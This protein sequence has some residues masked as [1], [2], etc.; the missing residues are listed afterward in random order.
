[1]K[2]RSLMCLILALSLLVCACAAPVEEGEERDSNYLYVYNYGTYIDPD[3]IDMFEEETGL[4]VVYDVFDT[5][6][7]MYPVI[8]SGSVKYDVVCASEY[9]VEKL[10]KNGYLSE[11]NLDNVPNFK[12]V[13]DICRQ[14]AEQ[15]DPGNKYSVPYNWGTVGILYN[16][17]MIEEGEITKWSDLWKEEYFDE[18]MMMDSLRDIY[19]APLCMLGYSINTTSEAEMREATDLLIKQKELVYSYKTDAIRDFLLNESAAIGQIYSGEAL[20][21]QE[22]DEDMVYV[23][24]EEGSNIWFDCWVIPKNAQ[25]QKNAELWI[26]F[27][28]RPEIGFMTYEYVGYSTPNSATEEMIKEEYPEEIDNQA[29]FPDQELVDNCEI[30]HFLGADV[31][32]MY[33]N[34]WKELKAY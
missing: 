12:Y 32:R 3:V 14:F 9:T 29:L 4:T 19:V 10:W 1:M 16:S 8:S 22:D 7:E 27:M 23:V 21:C 17:R 15:F 11:I 6:E 26:D 25:S 2:K 5:N 33:N 18:I 13:N 30:F 24:P 31:D 34:F 28:L 20:Y